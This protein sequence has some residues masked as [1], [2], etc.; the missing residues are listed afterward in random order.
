VDPGNKE[1][2]GPDLVLNAYDL[3][4]EFDVFRERLVATAYVD[5]RGDGGTASRAYDIISGFAYGC[6]SSS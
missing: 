2:A 5:R 3:T 4:V 1:L 6:I